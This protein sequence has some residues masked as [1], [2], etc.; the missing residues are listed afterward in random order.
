MNAAIAAAIDSFNASLADAKAAMEA[1]T[2][3]AE[4]ALEDMLQSRLADWKEKYDWEV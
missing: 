3:R 1:E 4:A 2:D